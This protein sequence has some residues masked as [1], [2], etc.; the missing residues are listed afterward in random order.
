MST[1]APVVDQIRQEFARAD[2]DRQPRP[3]RPAL[4][5]LTGATDYRVR[6]ALETI[7]RELAP[8]AASPAPEPPPVAA[9]SPVVDNPDPAA[10]R[11]I[12]NRDARPPIHLALLALLAAPAFVAVW[13]GWVGLGGLAGFG[14]VHLLPGIADHVT[15][16]LAVTLPAGMEVY[17]VI[18]LRVWL[19]SRTRTTRTRRFAAW[20]SCAALVV[21]C[22]G[23]VA[24]HVLVRPT[25][26]TP[27]FVTVAVACLPVAILG[28]GAALFHLVGEDQ[29]GIAG[30]S[31]AA[32][33]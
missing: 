25:T 30:A 15:V 12:A 1:L 16:N 28:V 14:P 5:Q 29:R 6:K 21:G 10:V 2:N 33:S 11:P 26:S 8:P 22:C 32:S 17:A 18:G 31:K 9:M 23:Q 13:G 19:S 27:M 3:G 24:Y 7:E 20:S 4:V